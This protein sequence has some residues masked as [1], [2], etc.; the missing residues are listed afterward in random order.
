[1]AV[2]QLG[3]GGLDGVLV[4]VSGAKV[5]FYGATPVT[6]RA[7]TASFHSSSWVSVSSNITVGSALAAWATEVTN[8][9]VALGIWT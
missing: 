7:S 9:L 6:S 4:G 3:D 5:G 1:M 8:T 2:N